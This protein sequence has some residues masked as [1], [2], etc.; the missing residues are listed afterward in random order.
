MSDNIAILAFGAI[1]IIAESAVLIFRGRA[2]GPS[3]VRLTGLTVVI[4]ATLYLAASSLSSD[5]VSAA[6]A[7]LGVVAGYLVG[8]STTTAK[9]ATTKGKNAAPDQ[10]DDDI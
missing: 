1:V 4:I 7:V 9:R 8:R 2:W 10:D 5:R 3:S 6:Y